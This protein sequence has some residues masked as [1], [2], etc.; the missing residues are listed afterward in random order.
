M[1]VTEYSEKQ[2]IEQL[3]DLSPS[4]ETWQVSSYSENKLALYPTHS[5]KFIY[6]S[7]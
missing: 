3:V 5:T 2:I 1:C 4:V 6:S 7:R